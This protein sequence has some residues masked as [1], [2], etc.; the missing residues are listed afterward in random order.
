MT[1]TAGVSGVHA[2]YIGHSCKPAMIQVIPTTI[3]LEDERTWVLAV[4][5]H[6]GTPPFSCICTP[7]Y[8]YDR[9]LLNRP[10]SWLS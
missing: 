6:P 2:G 4:H 5:E 8:Y 7:H 9:K 1:A 10:N 3:G